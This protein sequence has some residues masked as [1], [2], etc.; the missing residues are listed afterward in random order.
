MVE[1]KSPAIKAN[2]ARVAHAGSIREAA[3][4]EV[5]DFDPGSTIQRVIAAVAEQRV[6]SRI[7]YERIITCGPHRFGEP[8]PRRDGVRQ[9]A[10][11]GQS[12]RDLVHK[13]QDDDVGDPSKGPRIKS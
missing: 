8:R 4:A 2:D 11:R 7:A 6:R 5:D 9:R 13:L 1:V 10:R 3:G 12:D